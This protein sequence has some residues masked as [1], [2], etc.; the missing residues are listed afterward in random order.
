MPAS[1]AICSRTAG[2]LS[3][4]LNGSLRLR[5]TPRSRGKLAEPHRAQF[6]AQ[7]LPR[8]T[9]SELVPKPLR[10][11]DDAPAH[12][13]MGGGEVRSRSPLP[14][15]R[16]ARPSVATADRATCRLSGPRRVGEDFRVV[17]SELWHKNSRV[18][19]LLR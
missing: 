11:V 15:P 5:V 2:K 6:R 7:R 14:A 9:H 4:M 8:D 16:G 17:G 19:L 1:R 10:E 12:D 13:A 3:K 18:E